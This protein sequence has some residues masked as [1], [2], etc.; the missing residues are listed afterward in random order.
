MGPSL[1]LRGD[2]STDYADDPTTLGV[3]H[4]DE[5]ASARRTD[6]DEAIFVFRMIRI[7][8]RQRE[9]IAERGRC[10]D[11]GVACHRTLTQ[12]RRA[13]SPERRGAEGEPRQRVAD[14]A[15][16]QKAQASQERIPD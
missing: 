8:D 7:E 12:E 10:V 3:G 15:A 14:A 6:K 9:R 13:Q 16:V 5:T 1:L 4:D 11:T 2:S